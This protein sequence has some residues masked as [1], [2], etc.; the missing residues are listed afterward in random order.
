[1]KIKFLP[2]F[3]ILVSA[4]AVSQELDIPDK[5]HHK[6][7]F[8]LQGGFSFVNFRARASIP[9]INYQG[10]VFG[11]S[12]FKKSSLQYGAMY[13]PVGSTYRNMYG[14]YSRFTHHFL[15]FYSISKIRLRTIR[16][17]SI[18]LGGSLGVVMVYRDNSPSP[19]PGSPV[20]DC[21]PVGPSATLKWQVFLLGGISWQLNS[22]NAVSLGSRIST[23]I[24]NDDYPYVL[25]QGSFSHI[26]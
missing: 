21:S 1:M 6:T 11:V 25:L 5:T 24:T 9:S 3:L 10:G 12:T 15:D 13:L 17:L 23:P 14:T 8:G 26:F 18:D 20:C 22:Q 16:Q 2:A 7:R 19:P 4:S